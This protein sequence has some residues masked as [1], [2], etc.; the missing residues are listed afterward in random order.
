MLIKGKLENQLED[1]QVG[2]A[3]TIKA[4]QN[5]KSRIIEQLES[6]NGKI[7]TKKTEK[8]V[9][10]HEYFKNIYLIEKKTT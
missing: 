8:E 4:K 2:I 6:A 9:I 5:N 3:N 1:E 7:K 10:V